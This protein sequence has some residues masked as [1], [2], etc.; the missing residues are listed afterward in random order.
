MGGGMEFTLSPN[1]QGKPP[2]L[3]TSCWGLTSVLHSLVL[4]LR[5]PFKA[6][7]IHFQ[8]HTIERLR[9]YFVQLILRLQ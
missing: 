7:S 9:S 6:L 1:G 2:R 5:R 3:I 4:V 8:A